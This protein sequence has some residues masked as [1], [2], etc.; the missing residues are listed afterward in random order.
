MNRHAIGIPIWLGAIV[1]LALA[2]GPASA[3]PFFDFH[4]YSYLNGPGFTVGTS[5]QVPALF[6]VIQP[7]PIWPLD[8]VNNEYT[9]MAAGLTITDVQSAGPMLILTLSGGS[10]GLYEDPLRNSVWAASP[11][12]ALVPATFQDGTAELVGHFTSMDMIFDTGTGTGTI[13]GT[14]TWTG[15]ARLAQIGNPAGWTYFGGVSNHA[16]LGIPV[17]YDLAWDPQIYGPEETPVLNSSWGAIKHTFS[18]RR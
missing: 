4:G 3:L 10:I 11:P 5:V 18:Q 1:I 6:N 14:I 12:S 8:F 15:G 9:I 2:A 13:S 17:G 16:G 7:D